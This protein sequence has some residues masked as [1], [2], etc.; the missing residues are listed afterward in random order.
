MDE[1]IKAHEQIEKYDLQAKFDTPTERMFYEAFQKVE[2]ETSGYKFV[3]KLVVKR[4][5]LDF[6][7]IGKKK[8]DVEIDGPQHEIIEGMP[9]L[10]DVER[11]EFIKKEGWEIMRFPNYRILS[12]MPNV[13]NELLVKLK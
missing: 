3:P 12:D 5:T 6:A 9:V 7:I 1:N 11:D 8:I 13:I 4:Y 10:E 2:V